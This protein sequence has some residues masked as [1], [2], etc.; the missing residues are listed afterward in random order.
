MEQPTVLLKATYPQDGGSQWLHSVK[1][2]STHYLLCLFTLSTLHLQ[3]QNQ[4]DLGSWNV[5]SIKSPISDRWGVFLE[6]QIRSLKFYHHFHYHEIKGGVN[7]ALDKN[8]SF[9]IAGGKYDTYQ[10]G[11]NFVTPRASD[12]FR[13]FQQ[14]TMSQYLH[15]VKFEHRYRAEQ[16]FT[17]NGYRNR[18][19]YRM[20]AVLPLNQPKIEPKAWYLTANGEVFFTDTPPYFERIRTYLG[21]GY[22]LT[23]R[24]GIQAGYLHQFDYRLV[25]ETG[26][27]F[28]QL[29]FLWDLPLYRKDQERIPSHLD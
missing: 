16:R 28:F 1:R 13:L 15:R 25:D 23:K 18:F 2:R 4:S 19:R 20:Q 12:E 17:K 10:E 7:Y 6:G 29:S 24:V 11:G 5:L 22:Q 27:D 3:A 26:R 9:A 8:F 21:A 14:V